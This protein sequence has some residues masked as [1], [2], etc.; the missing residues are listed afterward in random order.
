ME[1]SKTKVVIVIPGFWDLQFTMGSDIHNDINHWKAKSASHQLVSSKRQPSALLRRKRWWMASWLL[2]NVH[3]PPFSGGRS[4]YDMMVPHIDMA[5]RDTLRY[6]QD[7]PKISPAISPAWAESPSQW[8]QRDA[9]RSQASPANVQPRNGWRQRIKKALGPGL[10]GERC[11]TH[12]ANPYGAHG[13]HGLPSKIRNFGVPNLLWKALFFQDGI[14]MYSIF[15]N[16]TGD[17]AWKLAKLG[18]PHLRR[19]SSRSSRW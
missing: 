2:Q 8:L 1:K 18:H 10:S 16:P 19:C 9:G 5:V 13:A 17:V 15:F 6:S 4:R 12:G 14:R 7:I 11:L 3:C